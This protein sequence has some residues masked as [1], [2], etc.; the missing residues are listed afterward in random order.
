MDNAAMRIYVSDGMSEKCQ[1]LER[2]DW[3]AYTYQ[4]HW[5]F[6]QRLESKT[7]LLILTSG[8]PNGLTFGNFKLVLSC[9]RR[10]K[11]EAKII[12]LFMAR[13]FRKK[14]RRVWS[15]THLSYQ[16]KVHTGIPV[17]IAPRNVKHQYMGEFEV[18]NDVMKA[19]QHIYNKM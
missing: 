10:T 16:V 11:S 18:M 9:F 7:T 3:Y 19:L 13:K 8:V 12:N 1:T 14:W 5:S 6:A 2:K 4:N 15:L 17:I